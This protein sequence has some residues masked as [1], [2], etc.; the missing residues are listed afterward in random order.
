MEF[1]IVVAVFLARRHAQVAM[2]EYAEANRIRKELQVLT[3]CVSQLSPAPGGLSTPSTV[4]KSIKANYN[5]SLERR[6]TFI[7]ATTLSYMGFNFGYGLDFLFYAIVIF[8]V[9]S[10]PLLGLP[11]FIMLVGTGWMILPSVLV[12]ILSMHGV[13]WAKKI[14]DPVGLDF[15]SEKV[16]P[17]QSIVSDK[18]KV[19]ASSNL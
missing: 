12:L 13:T 7:H 3:L 10:M 11:P 16:S 2:S 14:I 18:T 19:V 6:M 5:T 17:K 15:V 8:K 1:F 4:T 9:P